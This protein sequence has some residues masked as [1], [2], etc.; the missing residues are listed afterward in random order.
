[1]I[2]SPFEFYYR[3]LTGGVTNPWERKSQRSVP[4]A[5][6]SLGSKRR[7]WSALPWLMARQECPKKMDPAGTGRQPS[8]LVEPNGLR[9]GSCGG[10]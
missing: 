5:E 8:R 1:M 10:K 2:G 7:L 3:Y 9:R 4:Y 6:N